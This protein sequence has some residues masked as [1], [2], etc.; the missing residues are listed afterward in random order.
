MAQNWQPMHLD[1]SI[2]TVPSAA[3]WLASVGHTFTHSGSA[4][5]WHCTVRKYRYDDGSPAPPIGAFGPMR[6]TLFQKLPTGTSF[7]ALHATEHAR[8]PTHRFTSVTIAYWVMPH[9]L[10]S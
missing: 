6:S 10:P 2:C 9:S 8:H 5:C 4:Q 1:L 7:T 3:V